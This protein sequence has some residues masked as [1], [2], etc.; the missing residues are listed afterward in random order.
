MLKQF[1]EQLSIDMGFEQAL[2]ANEDGS[3]SLRLEPDINVILKEG[4]NQSVLLYAKVAEL[5][6]HNTEEF[7]VKLMTANL[8][9]RETGG[10]ALGL[11]NEGKRVVLLDFL[12]EEN[13][14]RRF[15]ERLEDFVNYVEAWSHE[16]IE[17]SEKQHAEE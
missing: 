2:E 14:Y 6:T 9:G 3:Y 1:I 17:F 8:L 11:D 16:T 12:V 4:E 13:N 7:L 5:P 15:Y 10:A